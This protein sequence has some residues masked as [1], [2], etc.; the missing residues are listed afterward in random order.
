MDVDAEEAW[1]TV[2]E[3]RPDNIVI[4]VPITEERSSNDPSWAER[5]DTERNHMDSNA[6]A[7]YPTHLRSEICDFDGVLPTQRLGEL[8]HDNQL[9]LFRLNGVPNR[10]CT[11]RFA[12]PDPSIDSSPIMEEIVSTGVERKFVKCIQRFL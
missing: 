3:G 2:P 7:V 5:V 6:T 10:P 11:A 12:L 1:I 9:R 8:S 4:T